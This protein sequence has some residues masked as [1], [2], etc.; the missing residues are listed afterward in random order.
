VVN[1][2]TQPG[3]LFPSTKKVTL[4][5]TDTVALIVDWVRYAAVTEPPVKPNAL[6]MGV[7]L[8]HFA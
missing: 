3:I 1:F 6:K 7:V 2:E 5:A 8:A 4:D